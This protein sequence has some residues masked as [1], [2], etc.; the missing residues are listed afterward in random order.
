MGKL[1]LKPKFTNQPKI[2]EKVT[3]KE[4]KFICFTSNAIYL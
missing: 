3:V 2:T 1:K 4:D